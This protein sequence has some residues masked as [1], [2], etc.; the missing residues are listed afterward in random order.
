VNTELPEHISDFAGVALARLQRVGGPQ[1]ALRA[2]T[3]DGPRVQAATALAELGAGELDV[4]G[5][6]D[7]ALAGAV[8]CRAAGAVALPYPVVED[9]LAID[10]ARLAVVN[11]AAP[12]I[13]HGDLPGTWVVADLDGRSY[14]AVFGMRAGAKL[15]P[16]LVPATLRPAGG[17]VPQSDIDLHLVLGSWRVLGAMQRCVEIVCDHVNARIQFGKPLSAFQAVRFA[18]ADATLAVAGLYELAKYTMCRSESVAPEVRSADALVLRLKAVDTAVAVLRTSHQLL[19]ALGFCDESDISVID[20]HTQPLLRLPV[21]GEEL[22][23]RLLPD[24]RDGH[25]ETLFSGSA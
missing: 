22:A 18:V 5:S 21:N 3:E 23:L 17:M 24:I 16:F 15:G 6:S 11:P 25:L 19:G 9:L 8:L 7:D 13:D 1:A 14:T 10:G 4:R 20:R 2:E 12:R